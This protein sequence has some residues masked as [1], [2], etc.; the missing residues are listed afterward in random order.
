[1]GCDTFMS[2]HMDRRGERVMRDRTTSTALELR[3]AMTNASARFRAKWG[4]NA[5]TDAIATVLVL[6]MAHVTRGTSCRA[7]M[8]ISPP[9]MRLQMRFSHF[10]RIYDGSMPRN[11]IRMR[12][13]HSCT[14]LQPGNAAVSAPIEAEEPECTRRIGGL[15]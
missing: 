11:A 1:M 9:R 14:R 3:N 2:V 13:S 7:L 5:T 4:P 8:R 12:K 15:P 6:L 10:S